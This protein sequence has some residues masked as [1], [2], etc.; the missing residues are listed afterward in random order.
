MQS[1][2]EISSSIVLSEGPIGARS[3]AVWQSK[4][5]IK[6]FNQSLS[7]PIFYVLFESRVAQTSLNISTH[8]TVLSGASVS[9]IKFPQG[10]RSYAAL[11]VYLLRKDGSGPGRRWAQAIAASHLHCH[12]CFATGALKPYH[13]TIHINP[14]EGQARSQR[15]SILN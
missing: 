15:I 9:S 11:Q 6:L 7:S 2:D 4:T 1:E 12:C 10:R 13:Q 5:T 14:H 8:H 3:Q